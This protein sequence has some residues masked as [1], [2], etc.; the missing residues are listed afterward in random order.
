L[1]KLGVLILVLCLAGPGF[2]QEQKKSTRTV[3]PKKSSPAKKKSRLAKKPAASAKKKS[4]PAK[5]PP[6][7]AKKKSAPAKKGAAASKKSRS[8]KRPPSWRTGQQTPTRERYQEIQQALVDKRYLQGPATGVWGPESV[9]A[10]KKFQADQNLEPSGMLD[11]L[12]LITLGLGPR[13]EPSS[14]PGGDGAQA[15]QNQAAPA[16][17]DPNRP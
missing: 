7:S 1:R 10:L 3:A 6:A 13:R 4:A 12:S 8:K 15:P 14:A 2:P 5:K 9:E 11:S 16:K 17:T